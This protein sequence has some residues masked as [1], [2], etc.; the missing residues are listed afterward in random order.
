MSQKLAYGLSVVDFC[1][2][3]DMNLCLES[4]EA[5]LPVC[6]TPSHLLR[7]LIRPLFSVLM[8][9]SSDPVAQQNFVVVTQSDNSAARRIAN[10]ICGREEMPKICLSSDDLTERAFVSVKK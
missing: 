4:P 9:A 5:A 6:Y 1:Q 2:I 10:T 8:R 7:L 3:I